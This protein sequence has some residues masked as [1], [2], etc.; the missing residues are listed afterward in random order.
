MEIMNDAGSK[1]TEN[2]GRSKVTCEHCVM[3][4][5]GAECDVEPPRKKVK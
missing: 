2:R 1:V 5:Y 4:R 3:R